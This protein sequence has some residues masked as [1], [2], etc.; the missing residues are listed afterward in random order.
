[1]IKC[2]HLKAKIPESTCIARQKIIYQADVKNMAAAKRNA[3]FYRDSCG[4]CSIGQEL[5]NNNQ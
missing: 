4:G 2:D 3:C 5:F 1:M